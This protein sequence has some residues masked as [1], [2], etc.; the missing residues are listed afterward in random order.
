MSEIL[1]CSKSECAR[2]RSQRPGYGPEGLQ[3]NIVRS[4]LVY[5]ELNVVH[6]DITQMK[7]MFFQDM[8]SIHGLVMHSIS[9]PYIT[10]L[11]NFSDYSD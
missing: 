6:A 7:F 11:V 4:K 3:Y 9:K 10:I 2:E 1:T 8:L 5:L